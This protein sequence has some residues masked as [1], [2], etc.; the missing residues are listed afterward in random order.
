[1]ATM[2]TQHPTA[3]R[4]WRERTT[5]TV[6][7][8]G[9]IIGISRSSAYEAA[10]TG[11]IPTLRIGRRL[12]VPVARLRELLGE[13]QNDHEAAVDGPVGKVGSHDARSTPYP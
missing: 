13:V 1:M 11:E 2:Q 10:R 7:E 3:S 4:N 9:P 12:L 5:L 8:V 6:E